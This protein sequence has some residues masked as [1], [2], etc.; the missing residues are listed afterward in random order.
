M[1]RKYQAKLLLF[2]E[3]TIIKGGQA[4]AMPLSHYEASW[5][6]LPIDQQDLS[7]ESISWIWLSIWQTI[8]LL[9]DLI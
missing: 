3:Y 5:I 4:L 9:L 7:K 1:N 2:G 6:N 8:R